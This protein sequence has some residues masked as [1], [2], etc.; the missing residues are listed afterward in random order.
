MR[1]DP[2]DPIAY[3][4]FEEITGDEDKERFDDDFD[5]DDDDDEW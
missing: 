2:F 3:H 4:V 5:S 1:I